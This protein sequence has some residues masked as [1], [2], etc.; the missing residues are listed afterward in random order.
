MTVPIQRLLPLAD[1]VTIWKSVA[2]CHGA[3]ASERVA[4]DHLAD[5]ANRAISE[6]GMTSAGMVAG[7]V[8]PAAASRTAV[9]MNPVDRI[10]VGSGGD[11]PPHAASIHDVVHCRWAPG[12]V[13]A[14]F[15]DDQRIAGPIGD[16]AHLRVGIVVHDSLP[17][18]VPAVAGCPPLSGS[19]ARRVGATPN[20]EVVDDLGIEVVLAISIYRVTWTDQVRILLIDWGLVVFHLRGVSVVPSFIEI[21]C[22]VGSFLVAVRKR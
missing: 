9:S 22:A 16:V 2:V 6:G 14:Y 21:H 5:E 17:P 4:V 1:A 19:T 20:G 18:R 13:A 15:S 10:Q 12:T 3:D 11:F 8:L 7:H